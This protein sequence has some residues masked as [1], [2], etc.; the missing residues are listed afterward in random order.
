MTASAPAS[1]TATPPATRPWSAAKA[2][3][4]LLALLAHALV[5]LAW[6]VTASALM[7]SLGVARRMV[8]NSEYALDTGRLPQP[9]V[10]PLGLIGVWAAHRF[11]RWTMRRYTRAEAAYGPSVIAWCGVLLG[12]LWGVYNWAPPVQVGVKVGPRSGESAPWSMVGWV[13]YHARLWLPGMV[14]FVTAVA[15]FYSRQSP[16]V[17]WIRGRRRRRPRPAR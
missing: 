5:G 17:V 10:I 6:V 2:L 13:A 16:L 4:L 8:M 3:D 1:V 15:V 7:G 9:W 11:F 14:A 12:V